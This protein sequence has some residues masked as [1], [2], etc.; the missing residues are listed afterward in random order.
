[1]PSA[2]AVRTRGRQ[3]A[4]LLPV[5]WL[6]LTLAGCGDTPP[7]PR[8]LKEEASSFR[9]VVDAPESRLTLAGADSTGGTTEQ[10]SSF[11]PAGERAS[12]FR[13]AE[14]ASDRVAL[15]ENLLSEL[16]ARQTGD[17]SIVIDLPSDIL[18]DFDKATLR[19]DAE[20]SLRKAADLLASYPTAPVNVNGHTDGK[21][22]DAYND[23]LS[24]RRAQAVTSWLKDHGGRGAT[25][26][27]LGKRR[28]VADN[29][30]ADGSDNPDGRQR[31]R[32][33]EIIIQPAAAGSA[34]HE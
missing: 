16:K 13:A 6:G 10:E 33:V 18:F 23:P 22:T 32:R 11:A 24:L 31:N 21:G 17:Q 19:S 29:A 4:I 12:I 5:M 30:N 2:M 28:P 14:V 34:T 25:V 9:L 27:G 15:T 3:M 8:S 26:A 7:A 1:M 20:Q